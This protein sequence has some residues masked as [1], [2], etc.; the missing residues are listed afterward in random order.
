MYQ[1]SV[2][3]HR[4]AESSLSLCFGLDFGND[5][6]V[7]TDTKMLGNK[8]SPKQICDATAD[9]SS[10]ATFDFEFYWIGHIL[11]T[12]AFGSTMIHTVKTGIGVN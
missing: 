11:Q 8:L 10:E 3:S 4:S 6:T 7:P 5:T 9:I 1:V 12:A 2:D